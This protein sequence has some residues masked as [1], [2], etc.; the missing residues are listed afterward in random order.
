MLNVKL[1]IHEKIRKINVTAQ[2]LIIFM[3]KVFL[4]MKCTPFQKAIS[5]RSESNIATL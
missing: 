2:D 4:K 5:F 1:I 3:K